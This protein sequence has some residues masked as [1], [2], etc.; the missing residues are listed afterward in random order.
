MWRML[1]LAEHPPLFRDHPSL[2]H[3][4]HLMGVGCQVSKAVEPPDEDRNAIY[5]VVSQRDGR[6]VGQSPAAYSVA[7]TERRRAQRE[8]AP[9]GP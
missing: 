5:I 8:N 6:V 4:E 1:R 9:A 3:A 7:Q 2:S